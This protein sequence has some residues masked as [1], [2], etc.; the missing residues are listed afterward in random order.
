MI[1]MFS[2]ISLGIAATQSR[3]GRS[4]PQALGHPHTPYPFAVM[5][6][7]SITEWPDVCSGLGIG[8][9]TSFPSMIQQR[10]PHHSTNISPST[11]RTSLAVKGQAVGVRAANKARRFASRRRAL[12]HQGQIGYCRTD[13]QAV[14]NDDHAW[15]AEAW[16]QG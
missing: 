1:V 2:F 5:S 3:S 16:T 4:G 11:F 15:L 7:D 9:A 13:L 14:R 12:D 8:W 6:T 10:N